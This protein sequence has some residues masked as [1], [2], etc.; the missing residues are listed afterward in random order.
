M[1]FTPTARHPECPLRSLS[2][3]TWELLAARFHTTFLGCRL[4]FFGGISVLFFR[5]QWKASSASQAWWNSSHLLHRPTRWG[6]TALPT[7]DLLWS[8]LTRR[9]GPRKGLSV[10]DWP[11]VSWCS[12]KGLPDQEAYAH[13]VPSMWYHL[14]IFIVETPN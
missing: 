5:P 14:V 1:Q 12:A 8:E 2:A 6:G 3:V 4:M 7:L 10:M 13:A 9:W 11:L